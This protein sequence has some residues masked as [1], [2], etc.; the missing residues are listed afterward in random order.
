M[1][2]KAIYNISY[3]LFVL[4]TSLCQKQNG[5]IINTAIQVTST[6]N[7][8]AVTVNKANLTHDM[9]ENSGEF[10][11]SILDQTATFD[12]FKHF[13]FQSGVT[14]EKIKGYDFISYAENSIAYLNK[15]ANS[16]ISG[17]V[18]NSIDLGTHTMFIAD[19][20]DAKILSDNP[21]GKGRNVTFVLF[22]F[23]DTLAES[24]FKFN[25]IGILYCCKR[26]S[27]YDLNSGKT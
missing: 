4:T 27:K 25:V 15:Y 26:S 20:T 3:G 5:C 6:P 19:V 10:N 9:I 7:R 23:S 24:K 11:I 14:A 1:D 22:N 16:Y 8:I 18:V 21:S 12:I 13:G 17:K 2:N